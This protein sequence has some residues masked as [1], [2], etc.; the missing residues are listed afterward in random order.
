MARKGLVQYKLTSPGAHLDPVKTMAEWEALKSTKMD[1]CARL[2]Q[3]LGKRNDAPPPIIHEDGSWEFPELPSTAQ[4]E[5]SARCDQKSVIYSEFSSMATFL[6]S[7][8]GLYGQASVLINGDM[9]YDARSRAV[10][11]FRTDPQKRVAIISSVANAGLNLAFARNVI[12]LVGIVIER[13][14]GL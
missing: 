9:D 11:E 12:F 7:V 4:D 6:Q 13:E 1:F 8:L 3:H 2:L 10:E 5:W 14:T